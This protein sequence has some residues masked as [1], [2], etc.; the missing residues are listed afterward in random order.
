MET[1]AK[2]SMVREDSLRTLKLLT[3]PIFYIVE[4]LSSSFVD[5]LLDKI[6]NSDDHK[7]SDVSV[8]VLLSFNQHYSNPEDNLVLQQLTTRQEA[9]ILTQNLI[10]LLNKGGLFVL[11][12]DVT[13]YLLMICRDIFEVCPY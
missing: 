4:I 3:A 10:K 6:E 9:S 5:F 7:I 11:I 8:E 13:F 12:I 2:L 1:G